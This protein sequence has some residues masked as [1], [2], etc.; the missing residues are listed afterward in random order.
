MKPIQRNGYILIAFAVLITLIFMGSVRSSDDPV[1][2]QAEQKV[3]LIHSLD[4]KDLFHSYCASCHGAAGK[5]DGPVAPALNSKVADLT[6]I[7]QRH[8]GTFR[9]VWIGQLIEGNDSVIAH[10]T[11]EMPIWGPIFHQIENDHDYGHVRLKNV[12][13]YLRTMQEK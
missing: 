10:G 4:G 12:T 6:T 11:R 5:G 2:K 3:Q 9:Q 8:G 7:S 1:K 13:D